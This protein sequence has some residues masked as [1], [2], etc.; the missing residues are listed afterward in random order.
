MH[1]NRVF[2]IA[3]CVLFI[4]MSSFQGVPKKWYIHV[5]VVYCIYMYI[6]IL[7]LSLVWPAKPS[8]T[9]SLA[10]KWG[11]FYKIRDI[12]PHPLSGQRERV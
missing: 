2:G 8:L 1:T 12:K 5:H 7:C 4:E 3:K 11:W 9:L 10:T 6:Q